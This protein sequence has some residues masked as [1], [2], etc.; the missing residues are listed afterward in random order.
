M[1][2]LTVGSLSGLAANSYVIDVASGSTL[3]LSAGAVFPAGSIIQ[4]VSATK[5][6]TF[7]TTS[8]S[9][10]DITGLSVSI[11]PSSTASKFLVFFNVNAS[12][13]TN[14]EQATAILLKRDSTTLFPGTG[15]SISNSSGMFFG[16]SNQILTLSGTELDSPNTTSAI[17]YKVQ[18]FASGGSVGTVNR[19]GSGETRNVA[20]S[21]TVMEIAG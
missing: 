6:D 20:S 5:T 17:I 11:T 8:A 1:S 7:T 18:M 21:I 16:Q 13:S 4:V 2:E 3:D 12:N 15:G 19:R 14:E 10:V 9:A